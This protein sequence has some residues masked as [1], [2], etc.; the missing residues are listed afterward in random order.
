MPAACIGSYR[1]RLLFN[2]CWPAVV[3]ILIAIS[4]FFSDLVSGWPSTGRTQ[5]IKRVMFVTLRNIVPF[6]LAITFVMAPPTSIRIFRTFQCISFTYDDDALDA[7]DR[8]RSY[9]RVRI[10]P[11]PKRV[12]YQSHDSSQG[13]LC[14]ILVPITLFASS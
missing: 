1:S 5:Y 10:R 13:G 7:A 12:G 6:T 8:Q 14:A 3:V 4:R 11:A 9:L 2:S